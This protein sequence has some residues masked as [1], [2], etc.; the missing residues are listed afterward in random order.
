[1]LYQIALLLLIRGNFKKSSFIISIFV[2]SAFRRAGCI[3]DPA[4]QG[5]YES[6]KCLEDFTRVNLKF[7]LVCLRLRSNRCQMAERTDILWL[8]YFK[9]AKIVDIN[10]EGRFK[11][12][13]LIDHSPVH[14]WGTVNNYLIHLHILSSFNILKGKAKGCPQCKDDECERCPGI[15]IY[16][17]FWQGGGSKAVWSLYIPCNGNRWWKAAPAKTRLLH[18]SWGE[19]K[20]AHGLPGMCG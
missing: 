2:P 17:K 16:I 6:E 4:R 14:R 18:A 15:F 20:A 13:F 3:L 1:M 12:V 10:Y 11:P 19:D 9:V 5:Y 7:Q 8:K